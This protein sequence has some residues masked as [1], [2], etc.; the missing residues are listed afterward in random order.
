MSAEIVYTL[1]G[2]QPIT[3]KA[4]YSQ[5]PL[6]PFVG[7]LGLGSIGPWEYRAFFCFGSNGPWEYWTLGVLGLL[8]LGS[9]GPWEYWAL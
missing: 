1:H 5:G 2:G 7:V 6:L 4:H 9:N 8:N 3:P